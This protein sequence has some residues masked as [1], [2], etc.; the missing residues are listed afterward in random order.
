MPVMRTE[1]LA[2]CLPQF[3]VRISAKLYMIKDIVLRIRSY[4]TANV[5]YPSFFRQ[6][7]W[8]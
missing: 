1:L 3:R 5:L 4:S 6:R 8:C 2:A 7:R